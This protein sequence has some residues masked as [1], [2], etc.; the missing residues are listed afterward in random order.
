MG[1]YVQVSAPTTGEEL[2][3]VMKG[4]IARRKAARGL[5]V[6]P[7]PV[8]RKEPE[9]T[10]E[11]TSVEIEP[12]SPPQPIFYARKPLN[13]WPIIGTK[14][15]VR[16]SST[17]VRIEHVFAVVCPYYKVK[18]LDMISARRAN[19]VV[20]PRQIA[21]YLAK[22]LTPNSLPQVGR[23]FGNR[24]HTTVMHAVNK[25]SLLVEA[26]PAIRDEIEILSREIR[27]LAAGVEEAAPALTADTAS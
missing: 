18:H 12:A 5:N 22:T 20:I 10:P 17:R 2:K 26:S 6:V 14:Y 3:E 27:N 7:F 24:D 1:G 9:P 15:A 4:V 21:M 8:Q 19:S 13:F 23:Q 16:P 25:I 11:P